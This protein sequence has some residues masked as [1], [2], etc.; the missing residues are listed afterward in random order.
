M[1]NEV[2]DNTE[3]TMNLTKS[4]GGEERMKKVQNFLDDLRADGVSVKIVSTSWFP[5][6]EAQ[7]QEY[8]FYVSD[9][10][11]LGFSKDDILAVEDPGKD[12]SADKGD[13]IRVDQEEEQKNQEEEEAEEDLSALSAREMKPFYSDVMFA[14][15]STGNIISALK[16][17]NLLYMVERKGLGE[18]DMDYI[19]AST[20]LNIDSES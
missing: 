6:T 7:W 9:T 19:K 16:V 8:L 11:G 14:D 18:S 1:V 3:A 17:C 12:L 5:I 20:R 15:D 10:L 2:F 13:R 4:L